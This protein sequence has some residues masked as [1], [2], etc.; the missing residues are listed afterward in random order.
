[1]DSKLIK[2]FLKENNLIK[3][4]ETI[5]EGD[6]RKNIEQL[7]QMDFLIDFRGDDKFQ[8]TIDEIIKTSASKDIKDYA[9]EINIINNIFKESRSLQ[10]KINL[11]PPKKVLALVLYWGSKILGDCKSTKMQKYYRNNN[12]DM[13]LA[14]EIGRAHV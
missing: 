14:Y 3:L 2:L 13:V 11:I 5:S 4:N 6:V 8:T 1:M 10:D 9:T 12:V 7:K